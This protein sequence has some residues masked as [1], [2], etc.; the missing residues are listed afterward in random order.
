MAGRSPTAT[1]NS[2]KAGISSSSAETS[3]ALPPAAAHN[4]DRSTRGQIKKPMET[5]VRAFDQRADQRVQT[6]PTASPSPPRRPP[7]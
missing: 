5:P 7:R 6:A 3:Q 4:Q 2:S 1:A